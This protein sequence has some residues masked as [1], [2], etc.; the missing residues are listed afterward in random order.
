MITIA[1][2][3]EMREAAKADVVKRRE[4]ASAR[5][6][7]DHTSIKDADII[8][9]LVEL[10]FSIVT[11]WKWHG[12]YPGRGNE[13]PDVGPAEVRGTMKRKPV[14]VFKDF[15]LKHGGQ[16]SPYVLGSLKADVITFWG[17]RFGK[18]CMRDEWWRTAKDPK[19]MRPGQKGWWEAPADSLFMFDSLWS[20]AECH[21]YKMPKSADPRSK[22]LFEV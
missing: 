16:N 13:M 15:E 12:W 1:V 9:A 4:Y 21:G 18:E 8:G 7:M 2:T 22:F 10:A 11:G 6:Y 20:W 3:D 5:D 17:W 19:N 14:L